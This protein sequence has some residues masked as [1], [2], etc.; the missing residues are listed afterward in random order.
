MELLI[1]DYIASKKQ[2]QIT[3]LGSL[4]VL[5]PPPGRNYS[6]TAPQDYFAPKIFSLF[7]ETQIWCKN[8]RFSIKKVGFSLIFKKISRLRRE[9]H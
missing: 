1:R 3:H 4:K 9:N 2:V 6:L 7:F 5:T 8:H